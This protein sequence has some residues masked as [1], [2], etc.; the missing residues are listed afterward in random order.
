LSHTEKN[1]A[2]KSI[3]L[4]SLKFS[5]QVFLPQGLQVFLPQG[6]QV[7]LPQTIANISVQCSAIWD[8]FLFSENSR[9]VF[10]LYI[11]LC[12]VKL[13]GRLKFPQ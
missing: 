13:P 6:L 1:Y 7:F 5:L 4:V 10:I 12:C 8:F 2:Q 11:F 9:S 3:S